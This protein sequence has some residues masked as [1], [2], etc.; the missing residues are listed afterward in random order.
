M[1]SA[2]IKPG[3]GGGAP[4]GRGNGLVLFGSILLVLQ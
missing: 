3:T 4:K 1:T 2:T